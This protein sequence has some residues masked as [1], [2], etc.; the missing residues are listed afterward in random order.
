MTE[1]G[2]AMRVSVNEAH[3]QGH[4]MC[5]LTAPDLYK[6][7]D[8]DGHAYV[9]SPVVPDG[10]QAPARRGAAACPERAITVEE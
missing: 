9:E 2:D 6:L 8:E 3:C 5:A 1:E 10:L 4:T 7:D